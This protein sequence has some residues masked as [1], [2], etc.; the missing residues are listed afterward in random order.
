[1]KTGFAAPGENSNFN[2]SSEFCR[3]IYILI[4]ISG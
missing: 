2:Q 3:Q 1:M 4:V